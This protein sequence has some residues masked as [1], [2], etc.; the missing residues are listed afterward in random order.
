MSQLNR[1]KEIALKKF[2]ERIWF[3]GLVRY[4]LVG[5]VARPLRLL[6]TQAEADVVI[7]KAVLSK[8]RK[9]TGYPLL[10]CKNALQ[11]FNNDIKEVSKDTRFL[12]YFVE[13]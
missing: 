9:K 3:S 2:K 4:R 6:S 13:L 1:C 10:K 8:L 7:D 11:K 12:F 5:A